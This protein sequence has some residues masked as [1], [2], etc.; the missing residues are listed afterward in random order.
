[1]AEPTQTVG[2]GAV[3]QE[4]PRDFHWA[5]AYLRDD[6]QDLRAEVRSVHARID[7]RFAFTL[8]AMITMTGIIV[9][10]VKL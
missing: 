8:T 7:S 2:G 4:V 10:A 9:A 3:R 1:M 6:I 5:I